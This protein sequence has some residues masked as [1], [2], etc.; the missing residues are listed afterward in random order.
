MEF[1]FNQQPG[2]ARW[3]RDVVKTEMPLISIITP[4]FNGEKNIRQT[5]NSVLNQTFPYFEW[6]IVDDGSTQPQSVALLNEIEKQD[7]RIRVLRKENGGI[8]SARNYGIENAKADLILPLDGDDLL[9]P[10]FAECC[11]WMLRKNPDAAWAYTASVGFQGDTYLWDQVFDPERLK[12]ENHLTA[13]AL[14]RR[15]TLIAAGGY[16]E[17]PKYCNE[18]WLFWL[19]LVKMGEFPVQSRGEYLFWY[20]RNDTGVLSVVQRDKQIARE[21]KRLIA[22]AAGEVSSPGSPVVYPNNFRYHWTSPKLSEWNRQVYSQKKKTCILFLFPHLEMGGADKFNLDLI[23]RLDRERF[24]A[25]IITTIASENTWIQK[26]RAVTPNVFCMANFLDPRDY[27]EFVSYY[28]ISRQVDVLF[29]SNAYHGYYLVPWLREHFPELV[30]V[31]YVHME[32]WYWRNGGYARTSGMIAGITEKTYVCNSATEDVMVHHYGRNAGTVETVHIGVDEQYFDPAVV[33]PGVLRKELGLSE[34]CPVILFICRLHPQKRPFLMLEI[35]EKVSQQIPEAVF[36][37]V[38]S[39]PQEEELR[40]R[41][42]ALG[43][44]RTVRFLGAKKD[45]RP[46]YRDAQ[47]TLVCS[48][49]EGLSLTAYESCAM[50]VPVVSA[51]VGGQ[52]DLIDETVGALIPCLQAESESLDS[53]VFPAEEVKAYADALVALLTDRQMWNEKSKNCR[54]R[55]LGGFTIS[56][57]IRHFEQEFERLTQDRDARQK[58]YQTAQALRLCAPLAAELYCMEMQ[59]QSAET[60]CCAAGPERIADKVKRAVREGGVRNLMVKTVRWTWKALRF[61]R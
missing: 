59:E 24:E 25:G 53:R 11:W 3:N 31:D 1:D 13:T 51:D 5:C 54:E 16:R 2:L 20:R 7:P 18:D 50:G 36:A 35:A 22:S 39:G 52:K 61:H 28:I 12:R 55:I 33:C 48:L 21:N 56:S 10:T 15:R 45:V 17:K 43:L 29:V 60:V 37:V 47:A 34:T 42:K 57:M 40:N 38:G 46:Y 6:I 4:Y 44:T 32:E 14:I 9:E 23:S 30:I 26:F 49:K 58:R 41:V 27:A 19:D 8:A